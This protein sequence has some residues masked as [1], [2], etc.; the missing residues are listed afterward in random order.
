MVKVY[1][2]Q[3]RSLYALNGGLEFDEAD[4]KHSGLKNT[5]TWNSIHCNFH[6]YAKQCIGW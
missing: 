3:T 6:C 2:P 1:F 5:Y 4:R